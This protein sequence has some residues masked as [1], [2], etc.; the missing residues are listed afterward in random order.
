MYINDHIQHMPTTS[1]MY[2]TKNN[3]YLGPAENARNA[4]ESIDFIAS[5]LNLSGLNSFTAQ[6]SYLVHDNRR[7]KLKVIRTAQTLQLVTTLDSDEKPIQKKN[8][9]C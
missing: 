1:M 4:C 7:A 3:Y 5:P 8:S 2:S 6:L 9:F